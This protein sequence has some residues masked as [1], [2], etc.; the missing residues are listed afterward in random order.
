MY[1][2]VHVRARVYSS[3]IFYVR[4]GDILFEF[5]RKQAEQISFIVLK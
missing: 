1:V 3:V 4:K 2:C 5:A